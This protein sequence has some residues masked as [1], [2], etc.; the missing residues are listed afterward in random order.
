MT[1]QRD[2][3]GGLDA[4]IKRYGGVRAEW[5]DLSTGINPVPYPIPPLPGHVWTGLPD[6]DAMERLIG[7]ARSYWQVPEGA[8]ILPASGASAL[9]AQLPRMRPAGRVEI[10]GPTYNEH[11]A[12][13]RAAGWTLDEDGYDALVAVHPN[14]P[15]GLMWDADN[16][17]APLTI[18]DESFCDVTPGESHIALSARPGT[19]V[20][21]SFGKFWGHA[22]LRLGFAIGD[23]VIITDL[24]EALGP[25]HVSGVALAIGAEA[26]SDP[27]WADETRTRLAQDAAKLD[28]I[29]TAKGAVS[30]GG[31]DL[32][33]L[34]Q[35]Q[36]AAA[37]QAHLARH[38]IWSRIFPYADNWLRLGLPH[39][40]RWA[41]VEAAF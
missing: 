19:I 14:N 31:T 41:Q 30:L 29:V 10:P 1:T 32:F 25:W 9:I 12:A 35:V 16:L 2:H 18:I 28:K 11:G 20:L 27:A 6:T 3:G 21:K 26:L 36:D 37:A 33:R 13:F 8:A 40:D 7:L 24:K 39:P 23:P 38:K 17:N 15:D 4:A 5:L 22:G 34:Y